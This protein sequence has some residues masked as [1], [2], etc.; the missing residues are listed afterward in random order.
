MT[1]HSI[2]ALDKLLGCNEAEL[3]NMKVITLKKK[4][5]RTYSRIIDGQEAQQ[6]RLDNDAE[7]R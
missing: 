1:T 6:L 4:N 2:E 5:G 7:L 3:G